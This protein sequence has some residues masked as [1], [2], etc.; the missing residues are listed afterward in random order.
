VSLTTDIA[1]DY[2]YIEGVETVSLTP[3][4]P[5]AT[6]KTGV[7]A[8][9]KAI[10][11]DPLV[12]ATLGIDPSDVVWHLW[13]GTITGGYEPKNGDI[14]TDADS[15]VFTILSVSYSIR[16]SRFICNCRQRN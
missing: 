5:A 16:S 11:G 7:Q 13:S 6:A 12:N 4:N 1:T 9:R 8:L 2:Q 14:I 10:G 3:Q 15:A